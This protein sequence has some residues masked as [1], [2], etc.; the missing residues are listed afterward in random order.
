MLTL[1]YLC[2]SL[3]PLLPRTRNR[4]NPQ[5]FGLPLRNS[6]AGLPVELLLMISDFLSPTER[7]IFS[8]CSHR[9]FAVLYRPIK[10]QV[11]PYTNLAKIPILESLQRSLPDQ[12]VCYLCCKLHTYDNAG[13]PDGFGLPEFCNI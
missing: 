12:Y 3:L 8:L 6:L 13:C 10:E 4:Q 7:I 11:S 2:N 9:L 1:K 5:S